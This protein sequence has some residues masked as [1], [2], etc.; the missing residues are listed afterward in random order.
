MNT[1]NP[2]PNTKPAKKGFELF[3]FLYKYVFSASLPE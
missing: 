3:E 2:V 1:A